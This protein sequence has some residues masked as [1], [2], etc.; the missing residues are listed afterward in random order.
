LDGKRSITNVGRRTFF[1]PSS[2]A[3]LPDGGRELVQYLGTCLR[4]WEAAWWRR[5]DPR[6]RHNS[7]PSGAAIVGQLVGVRF[8]LLGRNA[9]SSDTDAISA[10]SL[11]FK[12]ITRWSSITARW[13][14]RAPNLYL[15]VA[16]SFHASTAMICR[17]GIDWTFYFLAPGGDQLAFG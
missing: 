3:S 8:S 15:V 13:G 16:G 2:N 7:G 17:K 6:I 12:D 9:Y 10:L 11:P 1:S 14:L 5:C 4:V